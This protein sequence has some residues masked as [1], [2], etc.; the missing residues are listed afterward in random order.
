MLDLPKLPSLLGQRTR[1]V[2]V[3]AASNAIGTL[4]DIAGIVAVVR[5]HCGAL[6]FVDAVQSVPHLPV[7]VRALGCD[8]LVCSPY[9][10]FG[11]HQGVLW[12]RAALL[13]TI[14]AYKVRPARALPV[15]TRFE[16]GTPSFE[17]QAGVSGTIAYLEG[18]GALV[19]GDRANDRANDR[20]TRLR[21]AMTACAAYERDLGKRLLAGLA[22]IPGLTL[23]GPP[24]TVGR[25]PTFAFTIA[26]HRPDAIARAL[27]ERNIFVWSGHFYAV[28]VIARLGLAETGGLVRVGLAHYTTENEVDA[29]IAALREVTGPQSE[30]AE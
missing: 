14:T 18:L 26:G 13:E 15:A 5:Q 11:P 30:G 22:T 21:I 17:A 27:A 20:A 12:G 19:G 7:D 2:A 1:L 8:L 29:L 9:K 16:T 28:E 4:N 6:V 3:G 23:Y 25:V 24:T 10:F